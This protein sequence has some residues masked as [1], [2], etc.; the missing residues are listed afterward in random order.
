MFHPQASRE[1]LDC[2][3]ID[4]GA[5]GITGLGRAEGML[6]TRGCFIAGA[7]VRVGL[8]AYYLTDAR[9]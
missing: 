5:Q 9:V 6:H 1:L 3:I 4:A 8:G 2:S 7:G